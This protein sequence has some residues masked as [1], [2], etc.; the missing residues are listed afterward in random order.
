MP[1]PLDSPVDEGVGATLPTAAGPEDH[2]GFIANIGAG[3]RA[4]KAGA[5]STRNAQNGYETPY[6]DQIIKALAAEGK[7]GT[8]LLEVRP[9]GIGYKGPAN[10]PVNAYGVGQLPVAR[11]FRNPYSGT[12]TLGQDDN[13][14]MRLYGQ[15]DQRE[16]QAIWDAVNEVRKTK[17]DFLKGF[18]PNTLAQRAVTDRQQEAGAAEQ[19]TSQAG[20]LGKIGGFIGGMVGSIA[21]GDPEN[22]VGMGME[23]AAGKTI[24]R[25]V[26]KRGITE[27]ASN[28]LAG[29][30]ALPGIT[31]DTRRMG[32]DMTSSDMLHS[33][34]EQAALGFG[35]G[36]AH[37][38]APHIAGTAVKA[39]GSAVGTVAEHLPP[40]I[41]D[42]LA[43]AAMRAGTLD[44][45][46]DVAEWRRLHSPYG[47]H[48]TSTPDERAAANVVERD[49][50]IQEA[51]PLHPEAA[52]NNDHRLDAVASALGVDLT[53]PQVPT[54][55]P[56]ATPTVPDRTQAAT[57]PRRPASFVEAIHHAE[58]TA[59][60]PKSTAVGG[61][62]F[63]D[64]TWLSIAPRLTDTT[65]MSREAIL[66]L[67][68]DRSLTDRATQLYAQDNG[69]YLRAH[70]LED[71]PGN[72]SL[73]HFLG[74]GDAR[75]VL[76]ADPNASVHGIVREAAINANRS[77][78]EGKTAG[79]V[80][81]WANRRIGVT[82]D[83]PPARADAV[84]H[85]D[86]IADGIPAE[87]VSYRAFTPDELHT[88]APL[89]QYKS[90]GDAE[91]VTD[92]LKG[93]EAW[94][95]IM[96][97]QILAY[98]R[99]DGTH[100]VADG[101]QRTGL[102]KRLYADDPSI[103]LP[104]L[105]VREADGITP[106]QVRTLAALRNIANGTGTLLDNAKVLRDSPSGARQLAPNGPNAQDIIGLSKLNH[107][108]FGAAIN[109]VIDPAIA[110]KVGLHSAPESHMAMVDLLHRNRIHSPKEAANIVRQAAADGFGTAEEHQMSMFGETPQQSLY[111]PIARILDAAGK[112]LRDE[113]RTFKVLAEKANRIEGAGNKLDRRANEGKVVSSEEALAILNA[114][115]HRSGPVRDALIEAAR[116]ELSGSGRGPAVSAF[117]DK[118]SAIDLRS[119]ARG[120]EQDGRS[121]AMDVQPGHE[122]ATATPDSEL[123][124]SDGPSLFE[125]AVSVKERSAPFSDPNAE[126]AKGQVAL[127]EHDLKVQA[128]PNLAAREKQETKLKADS[129]MQ[130]NV[131]QEGTMGLSLFDVADQPTFRLDDEGEAQPLAKIMA[132]AEADTVAAQA[133]RDCLL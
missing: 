83:H 94:N 25:T 52:P 105:V 23:T 92:A 116:A 112:K 39:A 66:A 102:A 55:A 78:L 24:A 31:V 99:L 7:Q 5:H 81:E 111:V 26:I 85:Y 72:L 129:P 15:G 68:G 77:V 127:L 124:G 18:D 110:A 44:A 109:G 87:N 76:K 29:A 84:E 6:Y 119:A 91:G 114:T 12:P 126:G 93:V 67:R 54:P 14:L 128:D 33:V 57:S 20:T 8:D 60:N 42:P 75:K 11:P 22:A 117:L 106:E 1:G 30:A 2:T 58:G 28:A 27:G 132:D 108:A 4:A 98:E 74:A 19:V 121:G 90:G 133:A 82:V 9:G 50:D 103:R 16:K 59:R 79:Q 21:S 37:V 63:L 97:Q 10:L 45:R 70:G 100:V 40:A 38:V 101:H 95:P 3:Y 80:I 131:D 36:V 89:M 17:P 123:S 86:P 46:A 47:I 51:S 118:L 107:E 104:A 71:S 96:S 122:V 113:K 34:G 43:A 62:Q 13:P 73:A 130:A 64:G 125:Q 32:G 61:G 65:G 120:L 41:R 35:M 48:D 88:D 49:A 69:R 115:A 53:P 56:I